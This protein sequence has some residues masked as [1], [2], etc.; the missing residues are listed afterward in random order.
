[1]RHRHFHEMSHWNHCWTKTKNYCLRTSC[2]MTK[3]SNYSTRTN[4]R[5]WSRSNWTTRNL[6][7][8]YSKN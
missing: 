4:W 1:M 3:N 5:S 7:T 8:N 2:W 6:K